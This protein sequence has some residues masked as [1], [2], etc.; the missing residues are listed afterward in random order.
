MVQPDPDDRPSVPTKEQTD[1]RDT[2]SQEPPS[3]P[4][5]QFA[6]FDSGIQD[7]LERTDRAVDHLH[8][9]AEVMEFDPEEIY[10]ALERI[11]RAYRCQIED[12][13]SSRLLVDYGDDYVAI[14]L[15]GYEW[16]HLVEFIREGVTDESSVEAITRT[17][18]EVMAEIAGA[19][20]YCQYAVVIALPSEE[21]A[22]VVKRQRDKIG[23]GYDGQ[24]RYI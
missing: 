14:A 10:A 13:S 21:V 24:W 1:R 16:Y 2:L 7:L 23:G 19:E 4:D 3:C 5:E 22:D 20:W 12:L 18:L 6:P 17:T 8:R 15:D 11:Q 9:E